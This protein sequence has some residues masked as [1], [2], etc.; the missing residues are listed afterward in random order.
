MEKWCNI[1]PVSSRSAALHRSL[2]WSELCFCTQGLCN[3]QVW[4]RLVACLAAEHRN[5]R[6]EVRLK[7]S[8][9][10]WRGRHCASGSALT[11]TAPSSCLHGARSLCHIRVT[12]SMNS[13]IWSGSS[14]HCNEPL[15]FLKRRGICWVVEG[16]QFLFLLIQKVK[17]SDICPETGCHVW[18]VSWYSSDR[19]KQILGPYVN[20]NYERFLSHSFQ[21]IIHSFVHSS[22]ALQPCVG[23][24]PLLQFR[25]NFYTDCRTPFTGDQPIA[26]PLPDTNTE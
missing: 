1:S 21:F 2:G 12:V 24:W 11:T 5:V 13:F 19:S 7:C 20:L 18:G 6:S 4:L 3:K 10:P 9:Q 23:P 8:A 22:M 25:N 16:H 17:D 15:G 14:E 26:R